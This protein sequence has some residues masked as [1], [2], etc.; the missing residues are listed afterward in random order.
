MSASAESPAVATSSAGDA[1]VASRNSASTPVN[2]T[3]ARMVRADGTTVGTILPTEG[4][5]VSG[6]A[7]APTSAGGALVV[8]TGPPTIRA[9][10]VTAAGTAGAVQTP[11][12]AGAVSGPA[13]STDGQDRFRIVW[14]PTGEPD[15]AAT[16]AD[17]RSL[18]MWNRTGAVVALRLVGADGA[19]APDVLAAPAAPEVQFPE[20]VGLLSDGTGIALWTQG[21]MGGTR[22]LRLRVITPAG[23]AELP[24]PL[25]GG[26]ATSATVV[27]T[28][29]GAALVV[30][31]QRGG[32]DTGPRFVAARRF[33]PPPACGPVAATV[34]QGRPVDIALPCSGPELSGVEILTPP[35]PG[36]L[37]TL[38]PTGVR[39]LP[40]PGFDGTDRFTFRPLGAG[41]A[42]A[43]AEA[44][45]TVGRDT[46]PPAVRW[47]ALTPRRIALPGAFRVRPARRPAFVVR[48][49]EPATLAIVV[50]RR[51]AGR[52]RGVG[53]LRRRGEVTAATVRLGRRLGRRALVPGRHRAR[54]PATDAVGNRAP[55]R[56]VT[57]A[58]LR[59]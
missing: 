18:A 34:V 54:L 37:Q 53:V 48:L 19:P 5:G 35:P 20:E 26:G 29:P 2:R 30:W 38:G 45:I 55:A 59:P 58:V 15:T 57:F 7:V 8:W 50:Q 12:A 33:L 49:G 16:G 31:D 25:A 13:L 23:A 41:G 44:V 32:G 24:S 14:T 17:G 40:R 21:P 28:G 10:P 39:Y 6:P 43:P 9:M 52:W 56:T 3:E 1:V 42:G 4:P 47:F 11:V 36:S 46:M 22:S 27:P 51:V